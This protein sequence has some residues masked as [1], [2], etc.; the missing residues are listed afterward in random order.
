MIFMLNRIRT[1]FKNHFIMSVS[2]THLDVYKRQLVKSSMCVHS[3]TSHNAI[4]SKIEAPKNCRISVKYPIK[5]NILNNFKS[6]LG[7][8][9]WK[10]KLLYILGRKSRSTSFVKILRLQ[11]KYPIRKA[12]TKKLSIILRIKNFNVLDPGSKK[13]PIM[14]KKF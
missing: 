7:F 2:Y 11:D 13:L 6:Q 1:E 5:E 3:S 4:V 12:S 10:V 9:F 8:Q 14:K